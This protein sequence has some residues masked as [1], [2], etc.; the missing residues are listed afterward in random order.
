MPTNNE[1]FDVTT[2]AQLRDAVRVET[3][4]DDA[5]LSTSDL[6][7]IIDS[8]KRLL[9]LRAEVTDFYGDRGTAVA[10]LGVTCAKAKEAVENSPVRVD[11]VGPNDVTFRTS[12]GSSIQLAEYETMVQEG[13][14]AADNT[15]AGVQGIELTG[16]HF[17]DD[18]KVRDR[19]D[20]YTYY[21]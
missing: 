15:D 6:D 5:E 8:A 4:Y 19:G 10:L 3:Q 11:N 1:A 9:A 20:P 16:T 17:S 12:D 2:D 21:D 7:G 13:L 14:S 18:T